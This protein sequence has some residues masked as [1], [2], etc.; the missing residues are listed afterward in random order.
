MAA[1]NEALAYEGCIMTE[2]TLETVKREFNF[3]DTA[4]ANVFIESL[5]KKKVPVVGHKIFPQYR[6]GV[7][8]SQ[9]LVVTIARSFEHL[10]DAV[11]PKAGFIELKQAA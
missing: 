7:V 8:K 6:N 5:H 9:R 4:S 11:K 10:L 1:S 3:T 2:T